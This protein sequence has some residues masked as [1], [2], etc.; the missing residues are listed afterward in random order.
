MKLVVF[1]V[2]STFAIGVDLGGTNL[3]I[4][5]ERAD[6]G[7]GVLGAARGYNELCMIALGAG[8]GG[9]VVLGG[10]IWQ[11]INGMAGD[12]GDVTVDPNGYPCKCGNIGCAEQYA[13]A[14]AI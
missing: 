13:S 4:D 2:M 6:F 11:G 3:R 5:T 10:K 9:G 14:T 7:E 12:V 8:V 1:P